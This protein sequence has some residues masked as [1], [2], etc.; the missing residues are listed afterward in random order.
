MQSDMKMSENRRLE[1]RRNVTDELHSEH[2]ESEGLI[3]KFSIILL[4]KGMITM[5]CKRYV[6]IIVKGVSLG[7]INNREHGQ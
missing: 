5:D 3:S 4:L 6:S 1:I 7:N 2:R